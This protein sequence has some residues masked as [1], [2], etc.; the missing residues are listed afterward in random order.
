MA[1]SDLLASDASAI[2]GGEWSE[3]VVFRDLQG[4]ETTVSALVAEVEAESFVAETGPEHL[5]VALLKASGLSVARDCRV[6]YPATTEGRWYRVKD[7]SEED[8]QIWVL[9]CAPS[10]R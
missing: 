2:I 3:S 7:I 6:K 10:R 4:L 5:Q 1:F 8:A 9:I